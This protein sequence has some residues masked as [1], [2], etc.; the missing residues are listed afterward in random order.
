MQPTKKFLG[1]TNQS[2][3]AMNTT[4]TKKQELLSYIRQYGTGSLAYSALQEGM[5]DYQEEGYGFVPHAPV[6]RNNQTTL[7]LSDPI[8][9]KDSKKAL[10]EGFVRNFKNPVFLHVSKETAEV[11]HS[12][13]FFI[14][15]MGTETII[16]VQDFSLKGSKKEFLRSQRNR[17]V[18]DEVQVVE[19]T[20]GQVSAETMRAISDAW[21]KNKAVS[22]NELS[23]LARP[24]VYEEEPDVRR[25]FAIKDNVVIGF[26]FFDPMYKD[27]KVIGY[28][29]NFLRTCVQTSYSVCDFI[30][31]EAIARFKAEGMEI[32]SLGFSPLADVDDNGEFRFSK[33]LKAIFK[34]SFDKANHLYAFKQ[35]SFHKQRYRPGMD[36][37]LEV[38]VYCASKSKLP[39]RSLYAC[40]QKMGIKPVSQTA[41][42]MCDVA[43]QRMTI[44][45]MTA[46][47]FANGALAMRAAAASLLF[48]LTSAMGVSA[49]EVEPSQLAPQSATSTPRKTAEIMLPSN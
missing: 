13:G 44:P 26:V 23:F 22:S 20:N 9:A 35:L 21:M 7:C 28:L 4:A 45:P 31:V 12:M 48:L 27:G 43:K 49:K 3:R 37:T 30:I 17:A 25:F 33:P 34:Y 2:V 16:N 11:L 19:A 41:R 14:N 32:V 24:A 39:L 5:Q 15:E 47:P 40:V 10:L 29:A 36:G 18:K 42:H 8:C 38:K 1:V 46:R 6:N